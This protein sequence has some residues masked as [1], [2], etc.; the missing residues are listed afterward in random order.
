MP[1][2]LFV[3]GFRLFFF[4]GD[5]KEPVHI[6]VKKGDGD[7]KIWL[8]PEVRVAYLVGFSVQEEKQILDIVVEN[9]ETIIKKWNE[10]FSQ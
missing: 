9:R 4:S 10:Y 3:K 7:G 8:F 1:T 2:I 5:G 6:H